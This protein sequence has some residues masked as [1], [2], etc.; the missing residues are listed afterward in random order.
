MNVF[1]ADPVNLGVIGGGEGLGP[2]GKITGDLV[3]DPSLGLIKVTQAISSVIGIMTVAAGIWFILIFLTGGFYWITS[4]GDKAKLHEA[5]ER[6]NNALIGLII[7]VAG[8][9]ILA[10]AGQFFGYDIVISD[11]G[12]LIEQFNIK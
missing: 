8:W 11:P 6:I 1:A 10:L 2:F 3:K 9:S 12:T 4:S 7:V 5:R